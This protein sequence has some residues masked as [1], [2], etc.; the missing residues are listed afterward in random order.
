MVSALVILSFVAYMEGT[1]RMR[2]E[3]P[4]RR[5]VRPALTRLGSVAAITRNTQ[6]G[7]HIDHFG[8]KKPGN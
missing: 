3:Q 8:A 7:S 1:G 4:K 6:N 5:Y 2:R